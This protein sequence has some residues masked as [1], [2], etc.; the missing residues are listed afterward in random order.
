MYS[1]HIVSISNFTYY[2]SYYHSK[3]SIDF[4]GNWVAS[5]KGTLTA[6]TVII[7]AIEA[8]MR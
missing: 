7:R 1:N 3:Y 6:V 2:P 8:P 4:I 5:S